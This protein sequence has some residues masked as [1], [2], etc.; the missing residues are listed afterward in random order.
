MNKRSQN[1]FKFLLCLVQLSTRYLWHRTLKRR[2][3]ID[4]LGVGFCSVV[5]I[6][7]LFFDVDNLDLGLN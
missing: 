5:N 6:I 2:I 3:R 4:F 1:S 7:K